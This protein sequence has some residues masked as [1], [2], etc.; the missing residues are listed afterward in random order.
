MTDGLS[1]KSQ[2]RRALRARR[3]EFLDGLEPGE[4]DAAFGTLPRRLWPLLAP[5]RTVGLY[6]AAGD[7]APT[8]ALVH[9]VLDSRRG[10]ALP[11]MADGRMTFASWTP[12]EQLEDASGGIP[13]PTASATAVAPDLLIAPLVGFDTGLRR[14]GRGGGHYDRWLAEHPHVRVIGL[15]WSAQEVERVPVEAHDRPLD[16]VLTERAVLVRAEAAT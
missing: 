8:G 4:R 9:F 3:R 5:S 11:R 6:H 2:L 15:G 1:A 7:E 16:A 12:D 14:L 13:Q 10:V